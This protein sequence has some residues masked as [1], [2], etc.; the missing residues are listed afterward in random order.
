[1]GYQAQMMSQ[2]QA[3]KSKEENS[4]ISEKE[5]EV[6]DAKSPKGA[7]PAIIR[8]ENEEAPDTARVEEKS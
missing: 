7:I 2:Q 5:I 1:M 8:E 4:V 3:Q 6:D